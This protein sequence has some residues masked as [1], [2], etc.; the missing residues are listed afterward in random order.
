MY[1]VQSSFFFF[2][3]GGE[4]SLYPSVRLPQMQMV[5]LSKSNLYQ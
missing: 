3:F 2:F 4:L 5:M 1:K